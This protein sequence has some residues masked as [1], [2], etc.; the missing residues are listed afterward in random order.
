MTTPADR[1][2]Q[3]QEAQALTGISRSQ[4][5]N[6]IKHSD[7]PPPLDLSSGKN[8]RCSR[9]SFNEIQ[10]WIEAQKDQRLAS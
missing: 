6:L 7:F 2:L 3:I 9:W 5:Y 4:I 1:L 10:N 8:K